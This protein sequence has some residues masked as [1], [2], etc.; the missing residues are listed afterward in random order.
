MSQ[1][2]VPRNICEKFLNSFKITRQ[3]KFPQTVQISIPKT[4]DDCKMYGKHKISGF[5]VIYLFCFS[6]SPSPAQ[7][8]LT[9][10]KLENTH[11]F[12]NAE[13]CYKGVMQGMK[14]RKVA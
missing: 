14:L 7:G 9:A 6:R 13:S 12:V 3:F 5:K 1:P 8:I 2:T 11:S 4:K 10:V